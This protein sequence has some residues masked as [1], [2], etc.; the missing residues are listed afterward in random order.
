MMAYL[1]SQFPN[2]CWLRE[3]SCYLE[4]YLSSQEDDDVVAGVTK[5]IEGK[6]YLHR[7]YEKQSKDEKCV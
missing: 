5:H 3:A 2:A 4:Q 1:E 7:A 6:V